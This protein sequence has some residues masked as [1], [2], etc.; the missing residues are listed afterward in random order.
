MMRYQQDMLEFIQGKCETAVRD[1]KK[2]V[3]IWIKS[4]R[5]PCAICEGDKAKCSYYK[6]LVAKGAIDE[7]DVLSF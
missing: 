3:H 7:R 4:S 5:T 1:P 2:F 6:E